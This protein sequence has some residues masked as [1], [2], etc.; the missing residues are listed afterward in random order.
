V[1]EY[2]AYDP[3]GVWEGFEVKLRGWRTVDGQAVEIE[4][5]EQGWLWSNELSCWLV[6]DNQYLRLCNSEGM[7]IMSE[8]E[9]GQFQEELRYEAENRRLAAEAKIEQEQ[10]ARAEAEA[11]IEQEQLARA[12]AEQ[13]KIEAEQ[14]AEQERQAREELERKLAELQAKINQ[15]NA[16][17]D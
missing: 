17:E 12:E 6:A 2:F 11:K 4:P 15:N 7:Q 5:N 13:R 14:R 1:L 3:L 8:G 9:Y 10:L 16:S